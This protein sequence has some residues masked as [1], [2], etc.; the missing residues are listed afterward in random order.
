MLTR[1]CD[2]VLEAC[3][4]LGITTT[5]IPCVWNKAYSKKVTDGT[6]MYNYASR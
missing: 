1:C 3:V 2:I 4:R 5:S 6:L